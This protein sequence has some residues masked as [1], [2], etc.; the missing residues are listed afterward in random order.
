MKKRFL[1]LTLL[2]C[3]LC[4]SAQAEVAVSPLGYTISYEPT[5]F[6]YFHAYNADT[7]LWTA[8]DGSWAACIG[9]ER[10]SGQSLDQVIADQTKDM[11]GRMDTTV[12]GEDQI[13]IYYITPDKSTP[14]EHYAR[15]FVPDP[16]DGVLVFTLFWNEGLSSD[17]GNVL[18]NMLSTVE[19]G[20]GQTVEYAQC[21]SCGRFYP[22]GNVFRNHICAGEWPQLS[23]TTAPKATKKPSAT[24]KPASQ[25]ETEYA[26]CE[27]CGGWYEAGNV[28][29][30]HVCVPQ[31]ASEPEM[32]YCDIC[33]GWYEEGNVFRNHVCVPQ[34]ASEPEM[35][36]CDI[37]GGWYEEG[38]VFR[39]HVCVPMDEPKG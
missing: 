14:N 30:N 15:A 37:C 24:K 4:V 17:P 38:N 13:S 2:L 18:L 36:Y 33:G 21:E 6:Q 11:K 26:Y 32:V 27:V 22:T 31:Q 25:S 35:V 39:N 10:R 9:T 3:A 12:V 34:Q 8:T 20:Y 19:L 5:L 16:A 7:L 23:A 1:I 29:R 28:F